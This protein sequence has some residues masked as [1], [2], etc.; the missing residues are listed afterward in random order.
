MSLEDEVSQAAC[1]RIERR[2]EGGGRK[3]KME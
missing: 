1:R 3:R 2:K